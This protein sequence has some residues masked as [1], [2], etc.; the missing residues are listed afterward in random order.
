[1]TYVIKNDSKNAKN[2]LKTQ[3]NYKKLPKISVEKT[4]LPSYDQ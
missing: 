4:G 1:M 2:N 3:E